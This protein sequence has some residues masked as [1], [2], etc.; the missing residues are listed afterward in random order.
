MNNKKGLVFMAMG[1]EIGAGIIGATIL[2]QSIDEY[3]ST[4]G[5]VTM[6]LCLLVLVGWFIHLA[7]LIKKYQRDN[8]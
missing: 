6:V 3:Y 8:N 2:G 1:F 4:N 7:V 5:L